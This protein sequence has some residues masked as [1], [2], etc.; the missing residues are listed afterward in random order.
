MTSNTYIANISNA[1][2]IVYFAKNVWLVIGCTFVDKSTSD[3]GLDR[4]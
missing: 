1:Y 3:I 2:V 4:K